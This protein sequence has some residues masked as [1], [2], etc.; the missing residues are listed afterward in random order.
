[1][2][3]SRS[4]N[5]GFIALPIALS[6]SFFLVF[7]SIT[8]S[9]DVLSTRLQVLR[10]ES[11]AQSSAAAYSCAHL[12]LF[13][14]SA[15]FDYQPSELGD[16]FFLPTGDS[17]VVENVTTPESEKRLVRVSA[18]KNIATTTFEFLLHKNSIFSSELFVLFFR[19]I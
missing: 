4:K 5:Q 1:M 18:S 11:R 16:V 14:L 17:C 13:E 7:I 8:S 6:I 12:A 2:H 3:H 15:D 9:E 10:E 19:K